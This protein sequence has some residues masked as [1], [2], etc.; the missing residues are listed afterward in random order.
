MKG[1]I[2]AGRRRLREQFAQL[3]REHASPARL[4]VAVA[5]GVLVG[6]SPFLGFQ[7][8]LAVLLA[9]LF[10]LNRIAVLLGVQISIP[11]LMPILFFANA[12]VGSLLRQG[13][14]MPL[15]LEALRGAPASQVAA[16]L[17]L[18]LLVGG[19]LVGG[20][21]GAGLGWMTASL[22]QQQRARKPLSEHFSPEQWEGLEDRLGRLHRSWRS[23]A[24]W[25]LRLDPVY[26]LILPELPEDV[27]LVD[28]GA[29]MGL[30]PLLLATRSERCRIRAVEWDERKA[31]VARTLLEGLPGVQVEQGDA[32][33]CALGSPGAVTLLDVLHYSPLPEQKEWLL[34]C[35]EALRPGGLL[36]VRELEPGR[37][38]RPLAPL[39]ERWAIRFGWNR[40]ARVHAWSPAEMAELLT[41]LGFAAEVRPAG[42]GV[43][44]AN[45]LLIARKAS[46][47]TTSH[48]H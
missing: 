2:A 38:R 46:L 8:L 31:R 6:S 11:P 12:Q 26:A 7:L 19:L 42:S 34:R 39:L 9:M 14:W 37:S 47:Q 35:A 13:R 30:L 24:R 1:W 40:G 36:I 27:D 29:G 43:F 18:D 21:L 25:K 10:R 41:P 48:G 44:R 15:S 5:V 3:R 22:I 33:E 45:A 28:L 23:Y 32:R 20:V 17:F 16:D 4:G